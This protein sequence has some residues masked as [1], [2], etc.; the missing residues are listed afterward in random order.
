M[1][2]EVQDLK[3]PLQF[4]QSES[5]S[6][7]SAAKESAAAVK[8]VDSRVSTLEGKSGSDSA[9]TAQISDVTKK[10]DHTE[11]QRNNI[12]IDGAEGDGLCETWAET[13]EKV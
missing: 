13:E 3:T 9:H 5:D 11:N 2:R 7:K 1:V 6:L 4:S 10:I 12:V 8:L